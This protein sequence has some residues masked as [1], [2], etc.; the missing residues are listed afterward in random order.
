MKTVVDN[1]S[2]LAIE[3]F[4]QSLPTIFSPDVVIALNDRTTEIIAGESAVSLQE[5]KRVTE[6][7][8]I[9]RL[10]LETL[11]GLERHGGFGPDHSRF[12]E[13]HHC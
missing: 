12:M 4:L 8:D 5:R 7:L 2:V 1:I 6:K 3:K 10:S 9:L 13:F 11:K